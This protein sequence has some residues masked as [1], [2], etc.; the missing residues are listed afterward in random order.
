MGPSFTF[1]L[2]SN[3]SPEEVQAVQEGLRTF[4]RQK[5]SDDNHQP[6]TIFLRGPDGAIAGGLLGGTYWGWLHVDILWLSEEA[7]GQGLGSR[8]LAAAEAEALR[9]GCRHAHL[10]TMSFQAR[11]FYEK[12]GYSVFGVLEQLPQGHQRIYMKKDLD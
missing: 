5:A 11:G 3:P 9:R 10:D 7:R 1:A 2:E 8:L 6:L 12:H 4:N